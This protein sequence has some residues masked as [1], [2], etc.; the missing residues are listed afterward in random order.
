MKPWITD[1]IHHTG[2]V[3]IE[4]VNLRGP[5][6]HLL[7]LFIFKNVKALPMFFTI[8]KTEKIH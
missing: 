8:F 4:L 7:G 5:E 3:L 6:R 2:V 1:T